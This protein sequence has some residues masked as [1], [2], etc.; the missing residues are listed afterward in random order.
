VVGRDWLSFFEMKFL[1]VLPLLTLVSAFAPQ[2][3]TNGSIQLPET[4]RDIAEVTIPSPTAQEAFP[5]LVMY[6]QTFTTPDKQPLSLLPLLKYE[7]KVTHVVLASVHLHEEPGVIRLNNDPFEAPTWDVI[8]EEVKILQKHG[9]KVMALLG[10]AAAG[11]YLRLNGTDD[12]VSVQFDIFPR[13][14][15]RK[16]WKY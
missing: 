6:V 11:T 9:I 10:G 8:W 16:G 13:F 12:E 7:A 14:T 5:R 4:R 15:S 1:A 3:N 2:S